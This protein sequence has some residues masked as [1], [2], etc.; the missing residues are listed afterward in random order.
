VTGL[1][2]NASDK[3]EEDNDDKEQ[4]VRHLQREE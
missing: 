2:I 1:G 3:R 4:L